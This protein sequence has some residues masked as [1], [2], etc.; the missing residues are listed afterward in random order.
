[1][2]IQN[3]Q[4]NLFTIKECSLVKYSY[5]LTYVISINNYFIWELQ[6]IW[7]TALL[8]YRHLN[9]YMLV[10][11]LQLLLVTN[12]VAATAFTNCTTCYSCYSSCQ[13]CFSYTYVVHY[14]NSITSFYLLLHTKPLQSLFL[15]NV[16]YTKANLQLSNSTVSLGLR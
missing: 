16:S 7:L 2:V 8:L 11:V 9:L 1:M 6:G 13:R 3:V 12:G 4:W 5:N 15:A 10:T 14:Y